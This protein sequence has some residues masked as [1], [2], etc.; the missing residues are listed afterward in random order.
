MC[1]ELVRSTVT[2][3]EPIA[4]WKVLIRLNNGMLVT[5]VFRKSIFPGTWMRSNGADI[6]AYKVTEKLSGP[7]FVS[8]FYKCG[9]HCFVDKEAAIRYKVAAEEAASRAFGQGSI[10]GSL[11]VCR[12]EI[13]GFLTY[14][15]DN[16]SDAVV[17]SEMMV[18]T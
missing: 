16:R 18:P 12:V 3:T 17:A 2:I 14:G 11:E 15:T 8:E 4:A 10:G 1:L 5:P 9:F 6:P 7:L 13:N